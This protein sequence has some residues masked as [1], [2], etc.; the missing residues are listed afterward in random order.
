[1]TVHLHYCGRHDMAY[2]ALIVDAWMS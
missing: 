2:D 1:M